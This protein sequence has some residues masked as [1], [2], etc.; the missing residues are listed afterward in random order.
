MLLTSKRRRS[1]LGVPVF[2]P[3]ATAVLVLVAVHAWHHVLYAL[4]PLAVLTTLGELRVIRRTGSFLETWEPELW[5]PLR[6]SR[7]Q[8]S[9][10]RILIRVPTGRR[11]GYDLVVGAPGDPEER[12]TRFATIPRKDRAL[13]VATR[14][15]DALG[16]TTQDE[17]GVA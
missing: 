10:A 3:L 7:I 12:C 11:Y 17:T 6:R 15:G 9:P 5:A 2:M 13:A 8:A 4:L 1:V 14:V 16:L